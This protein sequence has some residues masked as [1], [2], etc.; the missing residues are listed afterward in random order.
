MSC[1]PRSASCVGSSRRSRTRTPAA[2]S[3]PSCS[4]RGSP[5]PTGPTS[6]SWPPSSPTAPLPVVDGLHLLGRA[7]RSTA[8][9]HGRGEPRWRSRA[10]TGCRQP[11]DGGN[12]LRPFTTLKLSLRLPPTWTP[13][14]PPTPS[15][16]PSAPTRGRGSPSTS[17]R[18]RPGWVAP[19]LDPGHAATLSAVSRER[20]GREPAFVGEGGT[21]PFL[22]DL[23]RGFPGT[24]FV[25][26]GVLGPHSN[27]HGPNESLHIPMA[28]GGHP[29][30]G[31]AP[32]LTRITA[33]GHCTRTR[34]L[35]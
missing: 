26:T 23:Q 15:S 22:P 28:Q 21:I 18:R 1:P 11:R 10:P 9:P 13:R 25:A 7:T 29:R 19:P 33:P 16:R 35:G 14:R 2:S 17:R 8:W 31:R 20:F 5:T 34:V 4:G 32:A 30:R 6:R 24:P 12:V 3:C 27:A